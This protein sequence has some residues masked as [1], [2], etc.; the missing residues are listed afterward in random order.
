MKLALRVV[1]VVFLSCVTAAHGQNSQGVEIGGVVY[2]YVDPGEPFTEAPRPAQPWASPVPN[3]AENEAGMIPFVTPDPGDYRPYRRPKPEERVESLSAFLTPGEDEP[4]WVGVWALADLE[5]LRAEVSLPN[6]P[7]SVDIRHLHC[8]PQRT[9]WRS[10]QFYITP[11]LILPCS[12][13][14]KVVPGRRGVLEERPFDVKAGETAAFWFTLTARDDARPG[15]Y[16]GTVTIATAGRRQLTLPLTVEVLPFRLQRPADR[17]W[18]LYADVARWQ[19]GNLTDEQ[20]LSELRDFARHGMTGLVEVPLGKPDLSGLKEGR[21]QFDAAPYR[22]L[23]E[24]CQRAGLPGPHVCSYGIA[25]QVMEAL[26]IQ[27]DLMKDQWPEEVKKG[28]SAVARAAVEATAGLPRW[29]F[30]GWDEPS[31]DNTYAVQDYQAWHDGGALTYATFYM[32]G[33]LEKAKDYLTAPCFGVGLVS[34]ED[35]ARAAREAC[36]KTGAEFWW[37]G[38]G[39]YVNPYPQES[40]LFY[41]RYGA[42]FLFW[43]TGA[44]AQVSWTFCRPH[45][46]VFNDFDGSPHNAAEPKEQ[47]TAYPHLLRPDDW[48]TYQGAIPT[49]AWEALREGWDDYRYLY[50]LTQVIAQARAS[51]DRAARRAARQAQERLDALVEAIPWANPMLPA[52]FPTDVMQ[53]ARRAVADE[54]LALQD[55]LSG[56][57]ERTTAAPE[58]RVRLTV[59]TL[60]AGDAVPLSLPAAVVATASGPPRVDGVLDDACW[61]QAQAVSDFVDHATGK[62]APIE[63]LAR[64]CQDDDALYVAFDCAEPRMDALV[65]RRGGRDA[66]GVWLEDSVEFFLAGPT[67]RPYAHVI[68]NVE[69]TLYDEVGQDSSWNADIKAAVGRR[70][71]G[72]SVEIALPWKDLEA[73]GIKRAPL[74]TGN[75]CRNR[76]AGRETNVNPHSAWS[77]P[78]GYFHTRERFGI[79]QLAPGPVVLSRVMVPGYWGP[80]EMQVVLSNTDTAERLAWVLF[81]GRRQAKALPPRAA[82]AFFF[83]VNLSQPGPKTLTFTYGAESQAH[84]RAEVVVPV[85]HPLSVAQW[86]S[87]VEDGHEALV[88]V[89]VGTSPQD[90]SSFRLRVTVSDPADRHQLEM[91]A[92]PGRLRRVALSLRGLATIRAEL[93]DA[94]GKAVALP[95]ERRAVVL[96]G[97]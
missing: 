42:G 34:G 5:G 88:V 94:D 67:R 86:P 85:P 38:T 97:L 4:L 68:V 84:Q 17:Y 92:K 21:V 87:L 93:L 61:E 70:R 6:A 39:S 54:I 27:A 16:K 66:D 52:A 41:N 73:A 14:R 59:R 35:S 62:P 95:I 76:F 90:P 31:G 64:I 79:L 13:G 30:Y 83:P 72:W 10:R 15:A 8:W 2:E 23:A 89:T 49:I 82:G 19:L 26:G 11:E 71:D 33:F 60:A 51:R 50:T 12:D 53:K 24:L 63:T 65:A 29:Y 74:M 45:E 96:G 43:K 91:A 55:L 37:Y 36:E 25:Y 28:V 78:N 75:F 77:F 80:Q 48:S 22:R 46:D 58:A 1:S 69:G 7:L 81:D 40:G 9:G 56:R 32:L 44:K 3:Q 57:R 47:V 20:I 18:L